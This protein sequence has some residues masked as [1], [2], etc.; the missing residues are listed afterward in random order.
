MTSMFIGVRELLPI[1]GFEDTRMHRKTTPTISD[2]MMPDENK[3]EAATSLYA[4]GL[5]NQHKTP[6]QWGAFVHKAGVVL[7]SQDLIYSLSPCFSFPWHV[8]EGAQ[9][10]QLDL[11]HAD[12][13]WLDLTVSYC[14]TESWMLL[15]SCFER[16]ED[17]VFQRDLKRTDAGVASQDCDIIM[18]A[19]IM[20]DHA[21]AFERAEIAEGFWGCCIHTAPSL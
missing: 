10:F 2:D 6:P 21:E 19:Q 20:Q 13:V 7:L 5:I 3:I 4:V 1:Q 18:V 16:G 9:P 12:E 14:Y 17:K 15:D 8:C 11:R